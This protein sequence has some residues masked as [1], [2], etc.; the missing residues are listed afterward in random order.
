M[1][2]NF[3]FV[4]MAAFA[5]AACGGNEQIKVACVGDSITEG[6]GIKIQ[7]RDDYPVVLNRILGG[8]RLHIAFIYDFDPAKSAWAAAHA[9][10]QKHLEDKFGAAIRVKGTFVLTPEAKQPF[11]LLATAVRIEGDGVFRIVVGHDGLAVHRAGLFGV[12]VG[13]QFGDGPLDLEILLKGHRAKVS[14]DR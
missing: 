1:K 11:E 2:H 8:P 5:F 14:V 12:H 3:L 13:R 9:Q 7:S 10:G 4:A 6:H